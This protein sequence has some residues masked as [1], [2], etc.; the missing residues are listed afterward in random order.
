[1]DKSYNKNLYQPEVIVDFSKNSYGEFQINLT[2]NKT[3]SEE[4]KILEK[5]VKPYSNNIMILYI[6]LCIKSKLIKTIKKN[7]TFF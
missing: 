6:E 5:K 3:L 1:M 2:F 7:I 4:K